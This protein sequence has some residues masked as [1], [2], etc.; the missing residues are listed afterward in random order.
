MNFAFFSSNMRQVLQDAFLGKKW[1]SANGNTY[2]ILYVFMFEGCEQWNC[3]W[4]MLQYSSRNAL[5][6]FF[7]NKILHVPITTE[8][9]LPS[10]VFA[11]DIKKRPKKGKQKTSHIKFKKKGYKLSI[12]RL[13]H[14]LLKSYSYWSLSELFDATK[15]DHTFFTDKGNLAF[16]FFGKSDLVFALSHQGASRTAEGCNIMEHFPVLWTHVAWWCFVL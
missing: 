10:H 1:Q 8:Q 4:E 15:H 16:Y 13:V 11:Q 5:Y 3:S 9:R 6:F 2:M 7:L 14:T 12:G